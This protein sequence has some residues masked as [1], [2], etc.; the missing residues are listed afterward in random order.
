MGYSSPRRGRKNRLVTMQ[1]IQGKQRGECSES[2][3]T[4]VQR[5]FRK[6]R[7]MDCSSMIHYR[8]RRKTKRL[9][10]NKKRLEDREG[11]DQATAGIM[12]YIL[13]YSSNVALFYS[14]RALQYYHSI[15]WGAGQELQERGNSTETRAD[16]INT[17]TMIVGRWQ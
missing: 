13:H 10:Y 7:T 2:R 5:R 8:R 4:A 3:G 17:S 14:S 11:K 15:G 6:K 9:T 1:G 16:R 12:Y